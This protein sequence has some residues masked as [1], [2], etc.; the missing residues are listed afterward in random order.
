MTKRDVDV[1]VV[2]GGP[3]GCIAALVLARGGARVVMVD[4]CSFPRD[5]ACGDLVGPRGLALLATLGLHPPGGRQVGEMVVVGPTGHRVVLPARAGRTFPGHGLAITRL[6]F[7]QW[8]HGVAIDAGVESVTA[9]MTSMHDRTIELHDGRHL[10]ADIVIGADGATSGVAEAAGLVDRRRVLWGFATRGYVVQD[11]ERPVIALWDEVPGVGFPGYGWLFPGEGGV[12]NVGLGIGLR[13]DRQAASRAVARLDDFGEH[14]RRL[15]ILTASLD[16]RRLGG[17]LKMGMVGTLPAREDV[18]LVGDAAGLVN[19]LQGEGI[20]PAM[21]SG[22]AAADAVLAGPSDAAARYRQV[23]ACGPGRYALATAPLHAAAI[24]GSPRRVSRVGRLIT[25][26]GVGRAIAS[27]WAVLWNDLIE[28]SP[29]GPATIAARTA[30]MLGRAAGSFT[31][32]H[33]Q[34]SADLLGD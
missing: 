26:R 32:V 16:V 11:V 17:W 2:G 20:A 6:R 28:G 7:D 33:E 27:P 30:A 29:P 1:V 25:A 34:L 9:R 5:K 19:P 18:L 4:K 10:T 8:L 13:A 22:A 31:V 3:A 15:G 23:L 14:L 12:A 21:V 24:S